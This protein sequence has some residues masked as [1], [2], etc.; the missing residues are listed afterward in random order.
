ML[1]NQMLK[2][3]EE[4]MRIEYRVV[5]SLVSNYDLAY[6]KKIEKRN[7]SNRELEITKVNDQ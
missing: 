7:E 3:L 2:T 5:K 6:N 4:K 1:L